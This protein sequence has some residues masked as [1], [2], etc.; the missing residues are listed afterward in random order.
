MYAILHSIITPCSHN[1]QQCFIRLIVSKSLAWCF[2]CF[3]SIISLRFNHLYFIF[4]Y[5]IVCKNC[6]AI[7]T[8]DIE[9]ARRTLGTAALRHWKKLFILNLYLN[10]RTEV[11][12]T[13]T[14]IHLPYFIQK[15]PFSKENKRKAP[16]LVNS[17]VTQEDCLSLY[18]CNCI[19]DLKRGISNKSPGFLWNSTYLQARYRASLRWPHM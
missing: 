13:L 15:S 14:T 6:G 7:G 4:L 17:W 9:Y 2:S 12:F 11:L 1:L 16:K 5:L 8:L 3:E 10:I 18:S 19:F